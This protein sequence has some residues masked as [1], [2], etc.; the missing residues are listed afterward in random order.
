MPFEYVSIEQ[1]I[2]RRGLRIVVVGN[3]PSAWSEAAKGILHIKNIDWVAVRLVYDN[4][5]LHKWAGQRTGPVAIYDNEPPCA[6]WADILALADRLAP[7]PALL[8]TD[9]ASRQLALNLSGEIC[10]EGGLG[11]SRR[12]QLIHSGLQGGGGFSGRV[13]AYLGKK[14]G[15]SPEA[16]SAAGALV[17]GMLRKLT[18][19]LKAQHAA[20]SAYY[21][22]GSLTA[23]DV[24]AAAFM[25]MFQPL[26][27]EQCA[28]DGAT[29]AAFETMDAATQA[30]LDPILLAHRDMMYA[31]HLELPLSL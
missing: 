3:V 16:G 26:P 11:W 22:G 8:P 10:G 5:G 12:L 20:G 15:Y 14:Y 28:M 25:A 21:V 13:A 18:A 1:A 29:R 31:Q 30:A 9:G 6:G 17:R 2:A 4:E 7:S 19:R 23:V 24:Y 27:H